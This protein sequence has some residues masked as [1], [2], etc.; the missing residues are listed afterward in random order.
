MK[1]IGLTGGIG[2][3]KSTVSR[4]LAEMGAVVINADEVAHQ[5]LQSDIELQQEIVA[6][7]GDQILTA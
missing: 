3:G 4:F 7:F 1:I 2:S 5:A 6:D